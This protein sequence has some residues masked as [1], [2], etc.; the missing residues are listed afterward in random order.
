[1]KIIEKLDID[2]RWLAQS[3]P[4]ISDTKAFLIVLE[5]SPVGGKTR[6]SR[7]TTIFFAAA[8]NHHHFYELHSSKAGLHGRQLSYS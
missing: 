4:Q 6:D 1:M 3:D 5:D 8:V 2:I 7:E